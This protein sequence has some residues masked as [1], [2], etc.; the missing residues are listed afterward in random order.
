MKTLQNNQCFK[1][2]TDPHGIYQLKDLGIEY[3]EFKQDPNLAFIRL[4]AYKM[5]TI[6][7]KHGDYRPKAEVTLAD[8]EQFYYEGSRYA[9]L[10]LSFEHKH[11]DNARIMKV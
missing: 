3:P 11:S 8:K 4:Y 7:S 6:V 9:L 2:E 1:V 5:P 10:L